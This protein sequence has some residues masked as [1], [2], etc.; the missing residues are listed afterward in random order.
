MYYTLHHDRHAFRDLLESIFNEHDILPEILEKD[1]Y[2]CLMLQEIATVRREYDVYFKGGTALY[3]CLKRINRF[4]EDID[5]TFNNEK[6]VSKTSKSNALKKVTSRYTQLELNTVH[7]QSVSGSGSRTSVYEYDTLFETGFSRKDSL[8][9]VGTVKVETTAFTT[10]EP[11][12]AYLMEPIIL[13]LASDSVKQ[14]LNVEY[15]M[16][17]F[18]M[19]V[20]KI[21]RIFVDKLFAVEDY[22][23]GSAGIGRFIEMGKHLYDL[24]ILFELTSI[25]KLL[26]ES[27]TELHFIVEQKRIEQDL[28]HE[29][30]TLG[31]TIS[32]FQYWECLETDWD[33]EKGYNRM[34]NVYIFLDEDRRRFEY[35]LEKCA[36]IHKRFMENSL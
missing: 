29:A 16:K 13:T 20:M 32:N 1:Y 22:Y 11:Y 26:L 17:P 15:N 35:V 27:E 24:I 14:I 5:L 18:E 2:V 4:S 8:R 21:E 34:Q 7:P 28:R 19:N 31:K 9:R 33:I 12:C 10:F 25:Q 23:L 6:F 3:K 36:H 30:K